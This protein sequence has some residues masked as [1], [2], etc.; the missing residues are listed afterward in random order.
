MERFQY[1]GSF[2]A[3]WACQAIVE[4]CSATMRVHAARA[5]EAG[6]S[7]SLFPSFASPAL[8]LNLRLLRYSKAAF[9]DES[10]AGAKLPTLQDDPFIGASISRNGRNVADVEA[11]PPSDQNMEKHHHIQCTY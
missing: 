3:F 11:L 5:L 4:Q 6:S 7:C 8:R 9:R 2:A 10:M 1:S